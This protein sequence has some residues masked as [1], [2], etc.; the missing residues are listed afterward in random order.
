MIAQIKNKIANKLKNWYL[1]LITGILFIGMGIWVISTP[2]SSFVALAWIFSLG[3]ILSGI[4]DIVYSLSNRK[5]LNS[6]GWYLALGIFTFL[7]GFHLLARPGLTALILC[8]YI[9]FWLFF[10]SVMHI[11]SSIE[12]KDDGYKNWGWILTFGI[13][14]MIFSFLLLWNPTLAGVFTSYWLGFGLISF[15]ILQIFLSMGL[16]RIK[17][18]FKKNIGKD[19]YA[20]YEIIEKEG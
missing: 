4:A 16:R 11:A 1:P 6:W 12:I 17:R 8:Y 18:K 20:D 2:I 19:L 14:G 9:G 5:Q 13:L 15:G 3:F 10:R 7:L